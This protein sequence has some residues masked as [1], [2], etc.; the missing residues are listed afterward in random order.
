M[1]RKPLSLVI[2]SLLLA[3]WAAAPAAAQTP[4]GGEDAKIADALSAGPASVTGDATVADWP[5]EPGG[6]TTELRAGENAWTCFP[7][8]PTTPGKDPMCLD[9]AFQ[10]FIAAWSAKETP[11]IATVGIGYMLVG[12]SDA[13]NTDPFA[14]EPAAGEEWIDAPPHIMIAVPDPSQLVGLPTDPDNGGPWVM[15]AGTPYAHIMIPVSDDGTEEGAHKLHG[16]QEM[17]E[18]QDAGEKAPEY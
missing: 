13:S 4:G 15:W 7:D 8:I 18:A 1:T 2:S 10:D 14:T 16:A 3:A 11:E 5:S 6:A 12:G 17:K 9:A